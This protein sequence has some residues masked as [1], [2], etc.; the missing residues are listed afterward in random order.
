MALCLH[1]TKVI[2]HG[3]VHLSAAVAEDLMAREVFAA[4]EGLPLARVEQ[5]T[6]VE[7]YGE[8]LVEEVL[9]CSEV[10][11]VAWL[12]IALRYHRA[13][14]IT[15]CG[16][17]GD[18][19]REDEAGCHASVPCEVMVLL[20]RHRLTVDVVRESVELIIISVGGGGEV[21]DAEEIVLQCQLQTRRQTLRHVHRSGIE[22]SVRGTLVG[23]ALDDV[24]RRAIVSGE[25]QRMSVPL[26]QI[27][28]R[29]RIAELRRKIRVTERHGGGVARITER[30]ELASP[31]TTQ[32][33]RVVDLQLL[34]GSHLP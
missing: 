2:R 7:R 32:T 30:I 12:A 31:R 1:V 28:E 29:E 22:Q 33:T 5:V 3:Q 18:V 11:A 27:V 15:T 9:S 24:R 8:R 17:D 13:S 4:C 14:L 21:E 19:V 34:C 20:A 10:Y 6:A 23:D 16:L 25:E 26:L